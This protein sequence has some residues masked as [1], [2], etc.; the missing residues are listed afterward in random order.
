MNELFDLKFWIKYY[1]NCFFLKLKVFSAQKHIDEKK[2]HV[3]E[4]KK[5]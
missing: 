2:N 3:Y 1:K 5:K 4:Y